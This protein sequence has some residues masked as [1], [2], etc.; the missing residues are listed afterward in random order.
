[1]AKLKGVTITTVHS[2]LTP[3]ES[4]NDK[5][6]WPDHIFRQASFAHSAL[7]EDLK[8][9]VAIIEN[10]EKH[11][12][13]EYLSQTRENFF[14]HQVHVEPQKLELIRAGYALMH[15]ECKTA[16]EAIAALR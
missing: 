7:N 8:T 16:D 4:I 10:F 5:S 9:S 6:E 1:M 2:L 12:A 15:G 11:R 3:L 14:R 13:W